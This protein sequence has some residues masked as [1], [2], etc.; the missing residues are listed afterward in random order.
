MSCLAVFLLFF[1]ST[2]FAAPYKE[3]ELLVRFKSGV[4]SEA[5]SSAHAKAG[6]TV[7][8]KFR[9]LDVEHIRLKQGFSV[10]KALASYKANPD[11]E[12]AEPNYIRKAAVIANDTSFLKQWGLHNTGQPIDG[13]SGTI[14]ADIDAPEAWDIVNSSSAIVVAVIDT[15]VDYSHVDLVA[16]IWANVGEICDNSS[17][18]DNNGYVDDCLGWDFANNDNDPMDDNIYNGVGH[19]THVSGISGALGNNG[20][21]VAG[22]SWKVSIMPLKILD[23]AGEGTSA[24]EIKAIQY[25]VDNGADVINSS[26]GGSEFSLFE[27]DAIAQAGQ[28]GV[29]FVAAAGNTLSDNDAAAFYPASHSLPNVISV[30]SSNS[31]DGLSWFSNFGSASVHIAAPGEDIYSTRPSVFNSTTGTYDSVYEFDSGTSMAASFVSGAVALLLAYNPALSA[32][33]AKELILASVDQKGYEIITGGRLNV[34]IALNLDINSITPAPPSHL[35]ASA[36]SAYAIE[37]SWV[38]N[39]TVEEGFVIER[40]KEGG[41]FSTIATLGMD[42]T[43]YTD[44]ALSE[45]TIYHYRVIAYNTN[46]NSQYSKE[47]SAR[48]HLNDSSQKCFVATAAYGSSLAPEVKVL[49]RFR[50]RY[51]LKWDTGRKVVSYYYRYSPPLAGY[52]SG[53]PPLRLAA[54]AAITPIVYGI[55]HPFAGGSLALFMLGAI[56]YRR[57]KRRKE[58]TH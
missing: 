45:D 5:A 16:N 53:R 10:S 37:L 33:E 1:A 49:R 40:M 20:T 3:G 41:T 9:A 24:D 44:S 22:L 2:V 29:L 39:S 17:D 23:T 14:D 25:A 13:Y 6:S 56:L 51:L 54:R 52:I 31:N 30:A 28:A 48:T 26:F 55:K 36:L 32:L 8:R 11:V 47:T 57:K 58:R 27:R 21:G 19:G 43:S 4:G 46:G 34:N 12:H 42:E 18:D 35:G 50:D 15:G 38:D 7:K